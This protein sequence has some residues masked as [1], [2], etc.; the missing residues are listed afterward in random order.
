MT[1]NGFTSEFEFLLSQCAS[2]QLCSDP[3]TKKEEFLNLSNII[4]AVTIR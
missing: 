3:C 1:E 4:P 2:S